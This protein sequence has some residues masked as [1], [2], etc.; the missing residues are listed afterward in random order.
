MSL[1]DCPVCQT[2]IPAEARGDQAYACMVCGALVNLRTA[3]LSY[4]DGGGQDVPSPEKRLLRLENARSRF[5]EIL[6]VLLAPPESYVLVD[7]G[8]GSGEMVEIGK[9][10]FADATGYEPNR[11]LVAHGRHKGLTIHDEYFTAD[12]LT[13]DRLY[14]RLFS[15]CHVLEHVPD[16]MALLRDIQSVMKEWDLIY[17]EV[18]SWNGYSFHKLRFGWSLWYDEH[19]ELWS[20]KTID[21]LSMELGRLVIARGRRTFAPAR[22]SRKR[23]IRDAAVA[24]L[25]FLRALQPSYERT[26]N[27]FYSDYI[28]VLLR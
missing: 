11:L 4:R 27:S 19:L 22:H 13:V 1:T 23:L 5:R 28:W 10:L 21:Y 26:V 14:N 25:R 18:P 2:Q 15:L 17:I 7:I 16:P 6:P 9:T 20:N 12:K 3:P 8:T 24:P